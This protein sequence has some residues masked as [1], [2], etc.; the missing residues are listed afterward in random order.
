MLF[1]PNLE[2]ARVDR[3]LRALVAAAAHAR[4]ATAREVYR[5]RGPLQQVRSLRRHRAERPWFP[6]VADTFQY[7]GIGNAFRL[8][9][10]RYDREI[11]TDA[12]DPVSV[13]GEDDRFIAIREEY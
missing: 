6:V 12:D 8:L 9:H 4:R 13:L 3:F 1:V 10:Q 7:V 2:P 5:R 11:D